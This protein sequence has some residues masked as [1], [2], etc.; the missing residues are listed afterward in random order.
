VVHFAASWTFCTAVFLIDLPSHFLRYVAM[1]GCPSWGAYVF[2]GC[3]R[4]YVTGCE[5]GSGRTAAAGSKCITSAPPG[6]MAKEGRGFGPR[7]ATEAVGLG[8]AASALDWDGRWLNSC[9]TQA[10]T[11]TPATK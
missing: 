3:I 7:A 9:V 5:L 8:T 4:E 6:P 1:V 2:G 11:R 10:H